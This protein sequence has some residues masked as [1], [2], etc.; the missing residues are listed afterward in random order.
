MGFVNVTRYDNA[1]G[2]IEGEEY[3]MVN[4]NGIDF[5]VEMGFGVPGEPLESG[6]VYRVISSNKNMNEAVAQEI[7]DKEVR[8]R[9]ARFYNDSTVRNVKNYVEK[10][11]IEGLR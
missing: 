2:I 7:K 9:L 10:E 3:E 8:A 4:M 6:R 5:L 1:K 11:I